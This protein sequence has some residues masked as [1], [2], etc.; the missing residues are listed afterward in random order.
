MRI[1]YHAPEYVCLD[2]DAGGVYRELLTRKRMAESQGAAVELF[3]MWNPEQLRKADVFHTFF[4][5]A[6]SYPLCKAARA[7]G[8]RLVVSPIYDYTLPE[9]VARAW[10]RFSRYA[11]PLLS[12]LGELARIV[13][14][15]DAVVV[16]SNGEL[17]AMQKILHVP[18]GRIHPAWNALPAESEDPIPDKCNLPD[19]AAGIEQGILFA[20]DV[21]NPRKNILRLLKAAGPLGVTTVICGPLKAGPITDQVM[22]MAREYRNIRMLGKVS[23]QML[24][25]LMG[26]AKVFALPSIYEGTGLAALEAGCLGC[27]VVV[28]SEGGTR[29][30]FANLATYVNPRSVGSIRSGLEAALASDRSGALGEHLRARFSAGHLASALMDVYRSVVASRS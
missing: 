6:G 4:P 15:A 9:T 14:M 3:Q 30:Y 27:N 24:S 26:R 11:W 25:G 10:I 22:A 12:H 17:R 5:A 28:T 2:G 7:A 16:R 21:A 1:L 19:E 18:I 29:D 8:C 20:G 23:R 13:E